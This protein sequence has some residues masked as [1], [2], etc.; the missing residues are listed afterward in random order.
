MQFFKNLKSRVNHLNMTMILT[1]ARIIEQEGLCD[2][3]WPDPQRPSPRAKLK[4]KP[5]PESKLKIK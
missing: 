2:S 5:S 1:M 3:A 4:Q